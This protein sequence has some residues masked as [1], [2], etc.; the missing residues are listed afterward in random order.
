MQVTAGLTSV[1]AGRND[2]RSG[3]GP[4][5]EPATLWSMSDEATESELARI[6]KTAATSKVPEP[7][8][9]L[10]WAAKS[11]LTLLN[12]DPEWPAIQAALNQVAGESIV[13]TILDRQRAAMAGMFNRLAPGGRPARSF[14]D[15]PSGPEIQKA[16]ADLRSQ[17]PQIAS[18][19]PEVKTLAEQI[20]A[21]PDKRRAVELIS[22]IGRSA[23]ASKL[24]PLALLIILW[25]AL[26]SASPREL[27]AL[28][29]WYSV[30]LSL[31]KKD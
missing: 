22:A 17:L 3:P 31:Y 14:P 8:N 5:A 10:R 12:T 15:N 2:L 18:T 1:E 29:V 16:E 24:S 4:R 27:A 6:I 23:G 19:L 11:F 7:L 20:T 13:D 9:E 21:D 26:G 30:A 28:A 25:W